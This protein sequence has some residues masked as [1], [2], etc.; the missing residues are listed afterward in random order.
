MRH[1]PLH[2]IDDPNEVRRLIRENPWGILV[3][4]NDGELVASHYPILLDEDAEGLGDL[5]PRRQ[6][7]RRHPRLRRPRGDGD[8]P[9]SPRIHLAELVRAGGKSAP[10]RG[11]SAQRTAM[12]CPRSSTRSKPSRFSP[13]LSS[14]SNDTSKNPML[15]DLDWGRPVATGT[16]G[17][18]AADH[19]VRLQDQDEPGQ[20]SGYPASGDGDSASAGSRS[21][22]PSSRTTWPGLCPQTDRPEAVATRTWVV[23]ASP[24]ASPPSPLAA[25]TGPG[26]GC[27]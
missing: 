26:R 14:T 8:S 19:A 25:R 2:A 13:D 18:R 5:H 12:A 17:I 24:A 22:I 6:A 7:R 21:T 4:H 9:G 23:A 11:T 10:R 20:D 27:C 3:S 16:V 15:L 1:N